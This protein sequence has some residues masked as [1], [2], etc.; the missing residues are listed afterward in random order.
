MGRIEIRNNMTFRYFKNPDTN[1]VHGYDSPNQDN[2]IAVSISNGWEEV[3]GS[4][5]PAQTQQQTIS[6]ISGEI[7]TALDNG[8][9][10]WGY[11][12]IVFASSYIN[13]K[14]PQYA[15][16]A[17]ALVDWRDQVWAWAIA[18]FPSVIPGEDAITFMSDMPSQPA[19]PTI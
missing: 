16:D 17:Q 5:P 19:Q 14:N 6:N 13:S 9:Y 11:D 15:A 10:Q 1:Y 3:T 4:W 12:S 8:A 2:L 7:Q 18:K